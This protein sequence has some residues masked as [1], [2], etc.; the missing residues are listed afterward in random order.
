[1]MRL[2]T[3]WAA[4]GVKPR[5]KRWPRVVG[6]TVLILVIVLASAAGYA[7]WLVSKSAPVVKGEFTIAG[8][9]KPV[10]VWR[11]DAGVPHIEAQ[12]EQ[13]LYI[14]QGYVTAQDRLFQMD[15][16]RR[17]A[18]GQLS[19]VVGAKAL[20][21]DKFFRSFSLRRAAEISLSA[22]SEQSIKVLEWYAQGVNEYIKQAKE[23]HSLP[24]EFTLMGYEPSEW[25]PMDSLTIGKFMAYDLG[26]R[27]EGQAFRYAMAQ[28]LPQE[29]LQSLMPTYPE[30]GATIIQALKDHP[31]DVRELAAAAVLPNPWNGSNNWV[32]S[33][34]KSASGSPLLANDPHLGLA[35]PSIWYETHLSAP[36]LSVSGVIFAGVPGIILGHNDTIA[37]G[38][39][40]LGPDVQDLYIEKRNPDNPH[41]FEYMGKWE[42][43]KVYKEEIKVKGEAPVPYEVVVTRHGPVISEFAKDQQK[44][45]VLAMR[46]T[47]LEATTELEAIQMFAKSRNWDEFKKSLEYFEAP[48]QNFV[49]A[50]KDG[51]IAYRGNGKIPIRKK[52]DGS[53]PVPGWT[54]EYEWTGFIPWDELPTAVNPK[55]GFIATANNKVTPDDYPYHLTGTW[56]QPYR[57][58]RI[59]QV[60]SSKEKLTVEDMQELQLDRSNLH[61]EEFVEDLAAK[62]EKSP[63]LRP[64]DQE[65][66]GLLKKWNKANDADQ[67]APLA[68]ELWIQKFDDVLFKPVIGDEYMKLFNNKSTVK[69]EILRKALRGEKEPWVDDAGGLEKAAV[70]A[71]QL[72]VDEAVKLQGKKP[73]Q[74]QWGN[75]HRVQ[76]P[77]NLSAVKP[78][79]LIFNPKAS[80]FGGGRVTVG[81]AGWNSATGE[82][83]HGAPWRTV[84]DMS[85]PLRSYNVVGPGQ[86][87]HVMSPWY[88]DQIDDWVNGKYHMT[89]IEPSVYR[90][91]GHELRLIPAQ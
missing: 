81:A 24:I 28:Q 8:L 46:W 68:Y 47:A 82:V 42:D 49:F 66:L 71:L 69:D 54:D 90:S 20:S 30:D 19:E 1:M 53:V 89:S 80:A 83:D 3:A 21:R 40:N 52:G 39:T 6:I 12:S 25:V 13:D 67:A 23:S 62:I 57:Q 29:K 41:Q 37:W 77:H 50:S 7:Y 85:D 5:K 86:S 14:A 34:A 56:A 72:A 45:T 59:H 51:T 11:D 63:E 70:Q 48:A 73:A 78:L 15:L 22:Y 31:A 55:E 35:T 91:S 74:W 10:T 18:S 27:W 26:G 16:S 4:A 61:A 84:I 9:Q 65:V 75:F 79:H 38:V 44:D 2:L 43:A 33:G 88:D 87:G 32:V 17:Q 60:L 58:E 76:F 64:V 36:E